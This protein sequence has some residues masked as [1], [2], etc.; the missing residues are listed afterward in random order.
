MTCPYCLKI[1][2]GTR[3]YCIGHQIKHYAWARKVM[4]D[5][6]RIEKNGGYEIVSEQEQSYGL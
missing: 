6:L 5:I 4:N 2:E 1:N 3:K